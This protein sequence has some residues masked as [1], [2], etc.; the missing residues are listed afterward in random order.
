M[1]VRLVLAV[2]VA[3]CGDG[4]A[5]FDA[6]PIDATAGR[7]DAVPL[8][9]DPVSGGGCPPG[10]K[11]TMVVTGSSQRP[12]TVGCDEQ[13]GDLAEAASCVAMGGEPD[14]CGPGLWCYAGYEVDGLYCRQLCHADSDCP[15]H[16]DRCLGYVLTDPVTGMCA[17]DCTLFGDDC[18]DNTNCTETIP[19]ANGS[20]FW[21]SC[22]RTGTA[23]VGQACVSGT[24]CVADAFCWGNTCR[25]LC[26]EQHGCSTGACEPVPGLGNGGG[27][28]R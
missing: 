13:P 5:A 6:A 17:M 15:A 22:R 7:P 11:C 18:P 19:N 20:T 1:R 28:C 2:V 26:D 12:W 3:A 4:G 23:G 27:I 16:A 14:L 21:L 10:E 8:P 9:C 25:S 24:D